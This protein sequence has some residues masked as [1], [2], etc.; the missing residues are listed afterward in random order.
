MALILCWSVARLVTGGPD[1]TPD[2]AV[3]SG[4]GGPNHQTTVPVGDPVPVT[5]HRVGR[6]RSGRRPRRSRASWSSPATWPTGSSTPCRRRD[7]GAGAVDRRVGAGDRGRAGPRAHGAG[8]STRHR[9][10]RRSGALT[11]SRRCGA[12]D[13]DG[14]LG[15]DDD[16]TRDVPRVTVA[17]VTLGC[18]RND[19]D[20]EELAGRL[21]A[22]GFRLVD[23]PEDA[24]TVVVNTCGFVE[25]AKKD[26]VDTL[27]AA[28]DLKESGPH[29]RRRRGRLPGRALRQGPRR[30]A[31]RGRR[32]ARLRRLPRHRG[33]AAVDPGR[34]GAPPAHAAGPPQAA[35]DLTGCD[36]MRAT[37]RPCRARLDRRHRRARAGERS[38][39]RTPA[40][41][42]W[43]RWLRSKLASGC[44][45]RCSFC[46]IPSFRGSFVSRRPLRRA[47]RGALAGRRG[48]PR[49]LPGQREQH[50][51]RQGPR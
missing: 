35:P 26:S 30:V 16:P 4:S 10:L 18:A 17:L 40:P 1:Q 27:L 24:E 46:A 36:A 7:A 41:G 19:V 32:R 42:R 23:D 43:T 29:A 45:R 38:A 2:R 25:A 48:R 3:L 15:P 50:V 14:I 21:A 47:G 5:C 11:G 39:R 34:R 31:A 37:C 13:R 28:A 49:D 20:S 8:G 6:W 22:D 9:V 12:R 33:P 51:V 44:D